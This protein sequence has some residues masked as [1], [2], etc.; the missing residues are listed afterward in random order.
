MKKELKTEIRTEV[1]MTLRRIIRA[2][3][4][5]SRYLV[6]H[7]GLTGPQA[8]ILSELV[9]SEEITA[10]ELAKRVHLSKG[11]IS[12]ILS[13]L[14]ARELISKIRS[15]N[16]RRRYLLKPTPKAV[17]LLAKAPPLLQEAFVNRFDYLEE[18]EQMSILASLLKI[19]DM[20]DAKELDASPVLS[21]GATLPG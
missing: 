8:L 4:I 19:A 16:D 15:D 12:G 7:H 1:L 20:M 21:S 9:R 13:R 18:Y 5:H 2:I 3:D 10:V 11:T 6:T 14:E 17:D